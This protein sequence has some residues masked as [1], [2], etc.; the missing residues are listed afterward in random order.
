M[1]EDFRRARGGG[2]RTVGRS[3]EGAG[4]TASGEASASHRRPSRLKSKSSQTMAVAQAQ[5]TDPLTGRSQVAWPRRGGGMTSE[6]NRSTH[7]PEEPHGIQPMTRRRFLEV[8]GITG[9]AVGAGAGLSGVLSACGS[10]SPSA[11]QQWQ[12]RH[13]AHHQGRHGL[14]GHR[15]AGRLRRGRQLLRH[16]LEAGHQARAS[17]RPTALRIRSRSSSGTHSPTPT[18]PRPWPAT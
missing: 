4:E 1:A 2:R 5:G 12:R 8:A 7:T 16:P 17:R 14:A 11:E 9:A 15:P 3:L 13:R 10:S 6:D 18:A